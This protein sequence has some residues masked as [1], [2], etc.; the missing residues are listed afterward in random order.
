M[1]GWRGLL[2]T[3]ESAEGAEFFWLGGRN[4][5]ELKGSAFFAKLGTDLQRRNQSGP[6][7][8]SLEEP[9]IPC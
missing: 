9:E 7:N 5:S 6:A 8:Q 3:T 2:F 1:G 4:C